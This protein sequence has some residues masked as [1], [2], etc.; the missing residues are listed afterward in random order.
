MGEIGG[1]VRWIGYKEKN[2]LFC[3]SCRFES[4]L[5]HKNTQRCGFYNNSL[6]FMTYCH[7]LPV[8]VGDVFNSVSWC[9][10]STTDFGSV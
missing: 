2:P 4:C 3:K 6:F 9:N 5:R 8:K 10:G 1:F 7:H